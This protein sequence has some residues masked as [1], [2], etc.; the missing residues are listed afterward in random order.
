M[1]VGHY[2]L[3]EYVDYFV[4]KGKKGNKASDSEEELDAIASLKAMK[5]KR[6]IDDIFAQM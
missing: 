4:D 1:K 2:L 6:E 5:R 3:K